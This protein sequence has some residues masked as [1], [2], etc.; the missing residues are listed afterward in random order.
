MSTYKIHT[1]SLNGRY[2]KGRKKIQLFGGG[3]ANGKTAAIC[4]KCLQLAKDYPGANILMAR[5]TYPKLNDTLR[6]GQIRAEQ[7]RD[8]Q[9]EQSGFQSKKLMREFG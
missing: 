1:G 2:L 5:S 9:I 7:Q 8:S 6:K 3:F 4:I